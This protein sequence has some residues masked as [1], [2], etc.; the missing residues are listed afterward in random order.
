[1]ECQIA[2]ERRK[3]RRIIVDIERR[4]GY[5]FYITE[6]WRKDNEELWTLKQGHVFIGVG[7]IKEEGVVAIVHRK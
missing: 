5:N 4:M 3:I 2:V 7:G 1:M 6:T